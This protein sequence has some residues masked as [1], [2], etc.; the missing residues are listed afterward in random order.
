M[1]K[2]KIDWKNVP[3]LGKISDAK[4]AKKYGVG[5]TMVRE[6]R[7]ALGVPAT[8]ATPVKMGE[9]ID[10][11]L[12]RYENAVQRMLANAHDA[13]EEHEETQLQTQ[14]LH[15]MERLLKRCASALSMYPPYQE[16]CSDINAVLQWLEEVENK[17]TKLAG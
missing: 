5:A 13:S 14:T 3:E 16:L 9:I 7:H 2:I 4:I 12:K 11:P 17:A 6:A 15:A 1:S 10:L 8:T